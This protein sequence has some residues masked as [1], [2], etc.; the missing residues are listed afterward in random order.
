MIKGLLIEGLLNKKSLHE[1]VRFGSIGVL[2]FAFGYISVKYV[3]YFLYDLQIYP[4]ISKL[5]MPKYYCLAIIAYFMYLL[6]V[7]FFR[8]FVM[9]K[10]EYVRIDEANEVKKRN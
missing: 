9:E 5:A 8:T 2:L 4:M 3:V 6:S 7:L 1:D 10:F